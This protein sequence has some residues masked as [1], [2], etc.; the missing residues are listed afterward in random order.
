MHSS[1]NSQ[2]INNEPWISS[3]VFPNTEG[4]KARMLGGPRCCKVPWYMS[5]KILLCQYMYSYST[6]ARREDGHYQP[7]I[8]KP[9]S[10]TTHPPY[11]Y[12]SDYRVIY[13]NTPESRLNRSIRPS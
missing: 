6:V 2:A 12:P 1:V 9:H 7:I 11:K 8:F 13:N 5:S 10:L 4:V 3:S